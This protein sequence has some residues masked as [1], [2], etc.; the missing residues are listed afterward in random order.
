M[1]WYVPIRIDESTIHG[2]GVFAV[3]TISKGTVIWQV[4]SSMQIF[5]RDELLAIEPAKL[6]QM[7]RNGYYHE[8][9]RQLIWYDGDAM[10]FSNHGGAKANYGGIWS[11]DPLQ[12]KM[13]ALRDIAASEELLEDYTIFARSSVASD[14][15]IEDLFETY[16]P[17]ACAFLR[18][19]EKADRAAGEALAQNVA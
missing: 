6:E 15:W 3:E 19:L 1:T 7:L 12:E 8:P 2:R 5:K 11:D 18:S 4:D 13:V 17:E 9:T 14:Q 16:S 10:I